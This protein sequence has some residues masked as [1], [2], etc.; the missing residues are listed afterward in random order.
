MENLLPEGDRLV[1]KEKPTLNAFEGFGWAAMRLRLSLSYQKV[2][3]YDRTEM[4][5]TSFPKL[6]T[7]KPA[8]CGGSA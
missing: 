4:I 2:I 1:L 6:F 3:P 8:H 5:P 7:Q